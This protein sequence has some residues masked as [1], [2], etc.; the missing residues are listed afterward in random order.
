MK[1]LV[2]ED[3]QIVHSKLVVLY[4]KNVPM[5]CWDILLIVENSPM[6]CTPTKFQPQ[7]LL[8][9]KPI[10]FPQGLCV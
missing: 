1:N 5:K 9:Y 8:I 6:N 2:K 3:N 7:P 4:L 10:A